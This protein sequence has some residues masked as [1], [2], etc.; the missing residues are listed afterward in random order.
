M[1]A[2]QTYYTVLSSP[3]DELLL[4]GDGTHLTGIYMDEHADGPGIGPDWQRDDAPF[5]DA[6][7]QLQA[8]FAG[9]CTAFDLPLAPRGT[10]FQQRVWQALGEIPYGQTVSYAEIARR[11]GQ[12]NAVRAVGRA[13]GSNP[14]S[15]VVPCHRV[16]GSSG[17]LTGYGGG[18]DRKRWLLAHE[19][20][21]VAQGSS[22]MRTKP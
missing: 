3:I 2:T 20:N 1:T 5:A 4:V 7:A 11:I 22:S 13:N 14:I 10:P 19:A 12:P 16:I 8:Y 17:S 9:E 15:I 6:I 18:L 21:V